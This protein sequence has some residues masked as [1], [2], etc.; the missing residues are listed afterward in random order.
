[1]NTVLAGIQSNVAHLVDTGA[2]HDALPTSRRRSRSVFYPSWTE[3]K[4]RGAKRRKSQL[5]HEEKNRRARATRAK[6]VPRDQSKY[7]KLDG[8][9]RTATSLSWPTWMTPGT[10]ELFPEKA[11]N[12]FERHSLKFGI[13]HSVC[14][15]SY[16]ESAAS[17][18]RGRKA[19]GA[20]D[21][22][23][24]LREGHPPRLIVTFRR[25]HPETILQ[26]VWK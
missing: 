23:F 17:E 8:A 14:S 25:D 18:G 11:I 12:N 2:T 3:R 22:G 20:H 1:M 21:G 26:A 16:A 19:F 7:D 24:A 15:G 9:L 4:Q 5:Q 13:V 10:D 6:T